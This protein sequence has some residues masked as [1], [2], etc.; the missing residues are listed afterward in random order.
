MN[1]DCSFHYPRSEGDIQGQSK[2]RYRLENFP[3]LHNILAAVSKDNPQTS[4]ASL[5]NPLTIYCPGIYLYTLSLTHFFHVLLLKESSSLS[6]LFCRVRLP[7]SVRVL[8]SS[9]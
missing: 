4:L 3:R 7:F 2:E 9:L 5:N 1:V 8:N 6:L